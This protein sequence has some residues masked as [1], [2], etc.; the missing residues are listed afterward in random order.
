MIA[1]LEQLIVWASYAGL[2]VAILSL[3]WAGYVYKIHRKSN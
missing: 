2:V 1:I 3:M